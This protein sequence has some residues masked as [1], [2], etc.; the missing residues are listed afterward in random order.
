MYM[1]EFGKTLTKLGK[2]YTFGAMNSAIDEFLSQEKRIAK[3]AEHKLAKT[4]R[5][6]IHEALRNKQIEVQS[7]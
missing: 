2:D 1:L 5:H 6:I 3:S 4:T 7:I